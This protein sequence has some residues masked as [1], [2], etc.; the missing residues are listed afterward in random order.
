MITLGIAGIYLCCQDGSFT[1][2]H[3]PDMTCLLRVKLPQRDIL[4]SS[5]GDFEKTMIQSIR[6]CIKHLSFNNI[7]YIILY[8][9]NG[10]QLVN[11]VFHH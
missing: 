1:S 2:F 5:G 11:Y 4:G 10:W 8:E 6:S 9:R 3:M 7:L